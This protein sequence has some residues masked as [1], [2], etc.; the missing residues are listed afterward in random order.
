[1]NIWKTFENGLPTAEQVCWAASAPTGNERPDSP[2]TATVSILGSRPRMKARE[3]YRAAWTLRVEGK[4]F[5]EIKAILN[6]KWLDQARMAVGKGRRL[7]AQQSAQLSGSQVVRFSG[8]E[9][10]GE[11]EFPETVMRHA[12]VRLPGSKMSVC[13]N[14]EAETRF[15]RG[16]ERGIC[17]S[18]KSKRNSGY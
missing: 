7:S 16:M 11:N 13:L 5:R 14:C 10:P 12:W 17:L 1:M 3:K 18:G 2:G 9:R 15:A 6:L 4:T 8:V